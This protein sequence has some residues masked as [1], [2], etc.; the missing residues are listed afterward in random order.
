[1]NR[2]ISLWP[3]HPLGPLAVRLG[4]ALSLGAL[5]LLA[6]WLDRFDLIGPAIILTLVVGRAI[7]D[8]GI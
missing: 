2:R 5:P 7:V 3:S 1:M 8:H 6:W 4:L